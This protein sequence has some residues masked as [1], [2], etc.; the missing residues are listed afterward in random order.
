MHRV[1]LAEVTR[2]NSRCCEDTS[3]SCSREDK[4]LQDILSVQVDEGTKQTHPVFRRVHRSGGPSTHLGDSPLQGF[5]TPPPSCS[6][7]AI[8]KQEQKQALAVALAGILWAAGEA[9]KA[10][11][12]LVTEDTYVTSTPDYSSDNFTERVSALLPVLLSCQRKGR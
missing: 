5:P 10:T 2:R 11:L 8:S 12:C 1:G 9:Q 3:S 6:L 7:C 4:A